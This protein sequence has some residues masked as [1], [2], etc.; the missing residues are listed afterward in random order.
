MN[1]KNLKKKADNSELPK[2]K[3][4]FDHVKAIRQAQDPNYYTN[5]SEDDKK[6]FN[7]FMILRAL[8]MDASLVEDMA[9]MYQVLDRIP[10][11]QFYQLMIAIV[12]KSY[13]YHPW[14]KTK[15][16]KHNKLLLDYVSK[17]FNV[18]KYQANEYVNILLRTEAGQEE[19]VAILKTFGLS[20]GEI[21][22]MFKAPKYD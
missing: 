16:M 21:E 8:S 1:S 5:L 20:D 4:V 13:Q 22:E 7:H 12:P 17:R 6:S 3:S 10:S 18:S 15:V 2:K 14:V 11:P 9:Q 19:L